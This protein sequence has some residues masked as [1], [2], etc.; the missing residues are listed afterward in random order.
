[1]SQK[2]SSKSSSGTKIKLSK[3]PK[4]KE[5]TG[6][7]APGEPQAK[8]KKTKISFKSGGAQKKDGKKKTGGNGGSTNG[9]TKVSIKATG[10]KKAAKVAGKNSK[11]RKSKSALSSSSS[12]S[13]S[14]KRVKISAS[15]P[16]KN[17]EIK[18]FND[19]N[20][21][22]DDDLNA[23]G[24]DWF[25]EDSDDDND[26][27]DGDDDDDSDEE[28]DDVDDR[29][30]FVSEED[31]R[32]FKAFYDDLTPDQQRRYESFRRSRLNRRYVKKLIEGVLKSNS[33]IHGSSIGVIGGS[34][35][36]KSRRK[37]NGLVDEQSLIIVAGMAKMFVGDVIEQ[38][39]VIMENRREK[40][41]ICPRHLREAYRHL[42]RMGELPGHGRF[43]KLRR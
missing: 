39:R 36:P 34:A 4:K 30:E 42:K 41:A 3:P 16:G 43:K 8:K 15:L 23:G 37:K 9:R 29:F 35:P 2:K 33:G 40:G 20:E 25:D 11:K 12:S 38:A 27:S 24:N 32:A 10:P 18:D 5:R 22:E 13:K 6:A 31:R 19:K 1:M 28:D 17:K 21:N 7:N 14:S 26:K